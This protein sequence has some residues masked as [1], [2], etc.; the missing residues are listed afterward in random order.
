MDS[1]ARPFDKS[2]K[3]FIEAGIVQHI[4]KV[5]GPQV[6]QWIRTLS[7]SFKVWLYFVIS[8]VLVL[9]LEMVYFHRIKLCELSQSPL[10]FVV[11]ISTVKEVLRPQ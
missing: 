3:I 4:K 9:L 10:V 2:L 7:F 11:F 8:S 6:S 1:V 5:K